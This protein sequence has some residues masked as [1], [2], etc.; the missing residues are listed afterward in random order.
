[1]YEKTSPYSTNHKKEADKILQFSCRLLT[2]HNSS[3]IQS[4]K[5]TPSTCQKKIINSK[6]INNFKTISSLSK[7]TQS[8]KKRKSSQ[9]K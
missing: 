6:P 8:I 1:M 9:S 5:S 4:K 2:K 7:K 3:L